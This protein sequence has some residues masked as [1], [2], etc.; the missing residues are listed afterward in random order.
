MSEQMSDTIQILLKEVFGD[1][2]EIHSFEPS[3]KT[4]QKLQSN[5]GNKAGINLYNFG[6]GDENNKA[7][8]FSDSDESGLPSVYKRK[9]DHFNIDMGQSEEIEI[10]T[11]DSFCAYRGIERVQLSQIRRRRPR[12]KVLDGCSKMLGSGAVDFI[13]FEF[14]GC[15]IDSRTYF[16]DLYCLLNDRYKINRIL[17]DGLYPISR[18]KEMYEAFT[19]TNYLAEKK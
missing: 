13:Q 11:L 19:T 17:K 10:K 1:K 3:R 18:Y 4:F 12:K 6:F 2:A 14:G 5:A 15:N 7:V 16:Q 9:L 8:L